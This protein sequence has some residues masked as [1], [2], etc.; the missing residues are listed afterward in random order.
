MVFFYA[1]WS[2]EINNLN[3]WWTNS[4]VEQTLHREKKINTILVGE[5]I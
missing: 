4:E 5:T 2:G 1:L 3:I